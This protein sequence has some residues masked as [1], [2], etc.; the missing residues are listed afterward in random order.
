MRD[1][2][3]ELTQAIKDFPDC[4]ALYWI[5]ASLAK[6]EGKSVKPLLAELIRIDFRTL[7]A[8]SERSSYSLDAFFGALESER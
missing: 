1:D 5:K 3:P 8:G 4:A 7:N 6:M 2:D